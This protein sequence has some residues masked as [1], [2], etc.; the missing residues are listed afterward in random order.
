[1]PA[2]NV[3]AQ[4]D[5]SILNQKIRHRCNGILYQLAKG[6]RFMKGEKAIQKI[7]HKK[8]CGVSNHIGKIG[9][10]PSGQKIGH[11]DGCHRIDAADCHK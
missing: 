9:V 6:K 7:G 3:V 8:A 2:Q 1:M 4:N 11:N 5:Y 10:E